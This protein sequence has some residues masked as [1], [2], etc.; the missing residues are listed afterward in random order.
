MDASMLKAILEVFKQQARER[1]AQNGN[2][3]RRTRR[4]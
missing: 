4:V 3:G 2:R 1:Q